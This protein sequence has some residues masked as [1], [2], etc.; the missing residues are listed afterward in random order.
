MIEFNPII[1]ISMLLIL[2]SAYL[3]FKAIGWYMR[4]DKAQKVHSDFIQW[5]FKSYNE[6][7]RYLEII[8][9]KQIIF[10]YTEIN[11]LDQYIKLVKQKY[12][13]RLK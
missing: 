9:Y 12:N 3:L 6:R 13:E 7:K 11:T 8:P 1:V 10:R 4:I 5:V 2:G